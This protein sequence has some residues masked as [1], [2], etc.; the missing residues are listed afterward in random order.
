MPKK[1]LSINFPIERVIL[2]DLL[3]YE[4]PITFSNRHFYNFIVDNQLKFSN[5]Y[6]SWKKKDAAFD[7]LVMLILG[8]PKSKQIQKIECNGEWY[9]KVS[10][11]N[12]TPFTIPFTFNI[13][14]KTDQY[15]HLSLIHPRSQIVAVSFY[16]NHKDLITYYCDQSQ[17]SLRSAKRVAGCTYVDKKSLIEQFDSDGEN[18]EVE[19]ENY[20]NLKSFFVYG[21]YNSIFNFYESDE[22][23]DCEGK[24]G[25]LSKLDIANCFASIYTHSI[26]WA[27]YSKGYAK[28]NLSKTRSTFPNIFDSLMQQLNY[29]ETNG[30]VIGPE[31]SRIFAE[32][33]LQAV[34]GEI[35]S[36]LETKDVLFGRDYRIY[37]Y[38]D[39][40]FVFY[41]DHEVFSKIKASI[42]LCATRYKLSLNKS[43]EVFFDR[44][45]VTPITI[46]KKKIADLLSEKLKYRIEYK[47]DTE[48]I[49][50]ASL[51]FR[52]SSLITDFK[53]VL[54]TSDV[55]YSDILNY[56]LS[57]LE[58]KVR[59]ILVD[60]TKIPKD[61]VVDKQLVSALV[62]LIEFSF[63]IYSMSPKVNGTIKLCRI[64]QQIIL[65]VDDRPLGIEYGDVIFRSIFNGSCLVLENIEVENETPIE[66]LYLLVLLRQL[67]R[68]YWLDEVAFCRYFGIVDRKGNVVV[69]K[70]LNY[71]SIVVLLFYVENKKRYDFVKKPVEDFI[72]EKYKKNSE[73]IG[74]DSEITHMTLDL[75]ACP[76]ISSQCKNS[77]LAANDVPKEFRKKVISYCS[78]WFTKWS[79]YDFA[80]ELDAKVSQDVY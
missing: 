75:M 45:I 10:A 33:I 48:E 14:H 4:V 12:I 49:I 43:K 46:A 19:G 80:K 67:G 78:T 70:D 11:K 9:S 51:H 54:Y 39:D 42:S 72:L 60:Y 57:I 76:Y 29:N 62:N 71:F 64:M 37:R 8:L 28:N 32:I 27:V 69:E 15:R 31:L 61:E 1:T 73:T 44:P 21:K 38:V 74:I 41:S 65:F 50:K 66:T 79:G 40:F 55:S 24:Y 16:K 30:I 47:E 18:I 22:Y 26:A 34:D 77:I 25:F 52:K 2:S 6:F 68:S 20:E 7:S 13:S 59:K 5:D 35:V 3:P 36:D 23:H 17:F 53:S 58:K 63:F 56:T